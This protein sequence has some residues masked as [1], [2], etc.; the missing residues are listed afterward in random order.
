MGLI[1]VKQWCTVVCCNL[2]FIASAVAVQL[3]SLGDRSSALISPQQEKLLGSLWLRQLRIQRPVI[4]DPFLNQYLNDLMAEL[5]PHSELLDNKTTQVIVDSAQLNA[6]AVP[7]GV[8]GIN[9]GLLLFAENE[10]QFVSVLAHEIVHLSQR[11]YARRVEQSTQQAPVAIAAL[12]A[13]ILLI[14]SDNADAGLAGIATSQAAGI[15]SQLNFSR[16]FE[17]EADRLG[18]LLV[19]RAGW[20]PQQM[21]GMFRNMLAAARYRS[22]PPEFLLT[23]PLTASRIADAESRAAVTNVVSTTNSYDF[24]YAKLLAHYR[25]RWQRQ[26]SP[27]MLED[28]LQQ[29]SKQPTLSIDNSLNWLNDDDPNHR[30]AVLLV[31][32]RWYLDLNQVDRAV[33]TINRLINIGNGHVTQLSMIQ[34]VREAVDQS[35]KSIQRPIKPALIQQLNQW[36]EISLSEWTDNL[37][38][39]SNL[40]FATADLILTELKRSKQ[41]QLWYQTLRILTQQNPENP[42]WWRQLANGWSNISTTAALTTTS[43]TSTSSTSKSDQQELLLSYRARAE[44]FYLRG[45]LEQANQQLTIAI[46]LAQQAGLFDTETAYR[47]RLIKMQN[48]PTK[49]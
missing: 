49:L 37:F 12:L 20:S 24:Y 31:L 6:F 2:I 7:G 38:R 34:Q 5:I 26:S 43:S 22:Q 40:D 25:Y 15:Q 3:P 29:S 35:P 23:H 18:M 16:E 46:E 8:V 45:N 41:R 47:T 33:A 30:A 48:S 9:L 11:H 14:A 27:K 39:P 36:L 21:P 32:T 17:R 19:T 28:W 42:Y 1:R 10:D 44:L 4:N 13:S